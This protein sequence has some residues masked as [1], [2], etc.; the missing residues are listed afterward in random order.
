VLLALLLAAALPAA[1]PSPA[2][3]ANVTRWVAAADEAVKAGNTSEAATHLWRAGEAADRQ[4][5]DY[6]RALAIYDRLVKEHPGA[7]L[8]RGAAA[9]RDYV[10]KATAGGAEPFRRFERVRADY[11]KLPPDDAKK[12]VRAI[13]DEHPSFALAD[14]ALLWLAE[15]SAA[16]ED[17]PEARRSYR[18]LLERFPD[19]AHA[20]H[21]WAG[22]GRAAFLEKDWAAAEEAFTRIAGTSIGGASLVSSKEVEIVR[23]HRT[24]AGRIVWV[25]GFLGLGIGAA[26]VTIDPRRL[27]GAVRASLG[28]ELLYA[29]PVFLLFV[30]IAPH[31]GRYPIAVVSISAVGFLWAVLVWADA[32]R[33]ALAQPSLRAVSTVVGTLSGAAIV[34]T[35]LYALDLLVAIERLMGET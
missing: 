5:R 26:I 2:V 30:L 22:L 19:S 14:E 31:D 8:S 9:R 3:E 11:S 25:L 29:G 13:L 4:L 17:L 7:R 23:R 16:S 21:A 27:R 18:E 35:V 12:E 32:A 6:D 20:A 10:A 28:R 33:P 24:R 1:T 15:Y 34:Y